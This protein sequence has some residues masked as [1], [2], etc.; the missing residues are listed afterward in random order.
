[1]HFHTSSEIKESTKGVVRD[2]GGGIFRKIT[3]KPLNYATE[4]PSD[5]TE[6]NKEMMDLV[7]CR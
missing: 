5:I 2:A 3:Q 6:V 1:L 7:L 4:M